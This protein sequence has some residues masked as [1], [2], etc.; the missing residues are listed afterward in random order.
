M[1][2]WWGARLSAD[3]P[4]G[5]AWFFVTGGASYEQTWQANPGGVSG[6]RAALSGGAG[7]S[8]PILADRF[9][10]R[11]RLELAVQDLRASVVLPTGQSDAHSRPLV[12]AAGGGEASWLVGGGV[13]LVA[14]AEV[15]YLGGTTTV[16]VHDKP[17]D[18]L[19]AWMYSV[20]LGLSFRFR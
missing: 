1:R 4:V 18:T 9:E 15:L 7:L 2:P 11:A 5:G 3:F 12:G 19:P 6:Q 16:L 20:S 13:A 17:A 10:L 8:T 14:G